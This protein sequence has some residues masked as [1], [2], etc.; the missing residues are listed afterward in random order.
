MSTKQNISHLWTNKAGQ[1]IIHVHGKQQCWIVHARALYRPCTMVVM[2][3]L[4]HAWV[5]TSVTL[6][7][8]YLEDRKRLVWTLAYCVVILTIDKTQR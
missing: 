7:P 1:N 8:S 3:R 6:I 4:S 2:I 5:T